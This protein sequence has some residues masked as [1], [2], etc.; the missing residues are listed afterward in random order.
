MPQSTHGRRPSTLAVAALVLVAVLAVS[1]F[2]AMG[3]GGDSGGEPFSNGPVPN[4]GATGDI[5]GAGAKAPLVNSGSDPAGKVTWP[6]GAFSG[7][8][9]ADHKEFG[10]WRGRPIK[11]ALYFAAQEN[12]EALTSPLYLTSEHAKDPSIT[13]VISYAMWPVTEDAGLSGSASGPAFGK[14]LFPRAA[15]GEFDKYWVTLAENLVEQGLPDAVIRPGWEFNGTWYRWSATGDTGARQYAEYFRRIVTAMRS[16]PGAEFRFSWCPVQA[17][18]GLDLVKAYP[19][20]DFVD[21]IGF[22]VYNTI[23]EAGAD[24]AEQWELIKGI[25][26]GLEWQVAFAKQRG[27]PI[28][29]PEWGGYTN[30]NPEFEGGSSGDDSMFIKNMFAWMVEHEPA[31]ENYFDY[32]GG[33]GVHYGIHT[34]SSLMP[35]SGDAYKR[36]WGRQ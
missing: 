35:R 20:D 31:F 9:I 12:W 15:A 4:S 28:S 5:S 6:S 36:L 29:F 24:Q 2:V 10:T 7:A 13:P 18:G 19:G 3:R 16:V 14:A 26:Y 1:V 25:K 30:T 33:D 22:D 8:G 32:D 17:K 34:E 23:F 21:D 11:T 27:K